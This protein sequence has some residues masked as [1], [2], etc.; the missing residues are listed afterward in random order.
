M[1]VWGSRQFFSV[2]ASSLTGVTVSRKLLTKLRKWSYTPILI[3]WCHKT[4]RISLPSRMDGIGYKVYFWNYPKYPDPSKVPILRTR[5][6]AIQ[7]PTP[8]L[9]GPRI[10]RVKWFFSARDLHVEGLVCSMFISFATDNT[11]W[12]TCHSDKKNC[13]LL[14]VGAYTAHF[15]REYNK[16]L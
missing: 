4:G 3:L 8:P 12:S 1:V 9:E 5:T 14:Y 7:V 16:P 11:K 13:F 2:K 15:Y 10:L 6:P